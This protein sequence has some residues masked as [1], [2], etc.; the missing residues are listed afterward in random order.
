MPASLTK[1]EISSL[2]NLAII[3]MMELTVVLEINVFLFARLCLCLS[4]LFCRHFLMT[5]SK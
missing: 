3:A 4:G 2:I 1:F 5:F